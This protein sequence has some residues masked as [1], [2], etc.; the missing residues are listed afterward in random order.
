VLHL[1]TGGQLSLTHEESR[2]FLKHARRARRAPRVR[3]KPMPR[4]PRRPGGGSRAPGL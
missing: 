4:R 1:L 3:G 2:Q